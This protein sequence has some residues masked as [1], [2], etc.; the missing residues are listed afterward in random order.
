MWFLEI[1]NHGSKR[2]WL[3]EKLN[4][5][6]DDKHQGW[7]TDKNKNQRSDRNVIAEAGL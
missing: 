1:T 5:N 3:M 7:R 2:Q 4:E 6:E